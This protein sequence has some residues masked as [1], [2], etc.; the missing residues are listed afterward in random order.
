MCSGLADSLLPSEELLMPPRGPP[1][2]KEHPEAESLLSE[3]PVHSEVSHAW[4]PSVTLPVATF[5]E[6]GGQ[7]WK[8]LGLA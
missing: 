8:G 3:S 4:R 1:L 5:R 2:L 7:F 6:D